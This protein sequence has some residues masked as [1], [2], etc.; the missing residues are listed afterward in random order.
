MQNRSM[1]PIRTYTIDALVAEGFSRAMIRHL[2]KTGVLP[3]ANGRGPHAY[4]LD[5]HVRIL[6]EIAGAR[7]ARR[8]LADLREWSHT[9][10]PHA[11]REG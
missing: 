9:V 5:T 10:F 2:I 6:R 4:Y 11:F 1:T 7:D 3:R 8:T